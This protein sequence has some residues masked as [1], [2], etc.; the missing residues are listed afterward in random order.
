[1]YSGISVY[2]SDLET[3]LAVHKQIPEFQEN[4]PYTIDEFSSHLGNAKSLILVAFI[5]ENP[6]GYTI[7]FDRFNDGSFYSWVGGVIPTARTLG[8]YSALRSK[9]E[10]WAKNK[11]FTSIKIK[12]RNRRVEM[13]IT[14]AKRGYNIIGFEEKPNVLDN[15]LLHEKKL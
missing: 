11:G 15:R 9:Q 5:D 3:V 12:T 2:E 13:R 4:P 14:L 1:M 6:V 8:V 10:Q 7:G